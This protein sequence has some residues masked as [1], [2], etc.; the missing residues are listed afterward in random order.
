MGLGD[1]LLIGGALGLGAH[2][3]F[4][5]HHH[6]GFGNGFGGYPAYG[7]GFDVN[8]GGGFNSGFGGGFGNTY[9]YENSYAYGGGFGAPGFGGFY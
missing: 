4:G 9:G 7:G 6:N 8:F 2:E 3:L 1:D 5:H